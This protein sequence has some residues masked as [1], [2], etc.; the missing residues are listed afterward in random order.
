MNRSHSKTRFGI[1]HG[2]FQPFHKE[3]LDYVITVAGLCTHLTVAITNP[4]STDVA[5]DPE[6]PHRHEPEA[7]PFTFFE[8]YQMVRETLLLSG[9]DSHRLSIVP[10][11]LRR[12]DNWIDTLPPASESAFYIRFF[13]NWERKKAELFREKGYEVFAIDEGKTKTVTATEVRRRMRCGGGWRE[14][15]PEPCHAF[16]EQRIASDVV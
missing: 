7:N 1:A 14:L 12:P 13:S 16:I 3:H 15:T 11:N 6:S 5:L 8:R 9:I 4:F 2:R 10:L